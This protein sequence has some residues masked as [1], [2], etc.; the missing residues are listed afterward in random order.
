M[1]QKPNVKF[2]TSP[3]RSVQMSI[4]HL[5]STLGYINVEKT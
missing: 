4:R 2:K 3:Y 5:V 1:R